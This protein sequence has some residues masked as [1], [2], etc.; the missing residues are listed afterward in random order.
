MEQDASSHFR[1]IVIVGVGLIGGSLGLALKRVGV[2]ATVIGVSSSTTLSAA[3]KVGAIDQGYT[4]DHLME[5]LRHADLVFLCTPIFRILDL[6]DDVASAVQGGT[7]ITDVGS[8][9]V[10]IV[11]EAE[12][13]VPD[14]VYFIGGHPMAGAERRGVEAA[15]PYLFE[16]AVYVLTPGG[17]VPHEVFNRFSN[18]IAH[19]GARAVVMTPEEH[20]LTAPT[21]RPLPQMMAIA[22]VSMV[23]RLN[24]EGTVYLRL[25]AGGFRDM[26]RIASSPYEVWRDICRTNVESIEGMIGIYLGELMKIRD[27]LR[28]ERL[29]DDFAYAN[30]MRGTIPKDA[31]GFLHPL[32]DIVLV[33]EDRS[34]VI[35]EIALALSRENLN[36]SDIEV[37]KVREGEAGTI[38]VGVVNETSSEQSII[39]FDGIGYKARRR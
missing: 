37:L 18:L 35:A 39:V 30:R 11:R 38:R 34:G 21:A 14:G 23:G 19:L 25:A 8:T 32:Y 16:N 28:D 9:K 2:P 4:Y 6:L 1:T 17:N 27:H 12:R 13:V 3:V 31:K 36:I 22:L 15:D 10:E 26:T 29:G 33:A 5:A 24:E 20:D 7:V